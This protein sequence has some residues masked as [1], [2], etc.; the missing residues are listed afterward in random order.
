MI[1]A[2]LLVAIIFG[3]LYLFPVG[4]FFSQEATDEEEVEEGITIEGVVDD[5]KGR[6]SEVDVQQMIG[7]V[8]E[9]FDHIAVTLS[10]ISQGDRE[11]S[12]V[13]NPSQLEGYQPESQVDTEDFTPQEFEKEVHA[14]VNEE[15]EKEGLEPVEF[16]EEA[17]VVA[18]EKSRDMAVNNYFD[19][20]SPTYG[21]PFDMMD[22]FGLQYMAAGENIAMGQRS[23]EQVMDGWMNSD[24]H[25]A[26]ILSDSFTHLG[27]G[28]VQDGH[29]TYWTQMFIGK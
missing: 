14:L 10:Q 11:A 19:H 7:S 16:S 17:S 28:Y 20:Q 4:E 5:F 6:M 29:Q 15:R 18:R 27:V 23:P 22:E 3:A 26:N 12:P 13:F 8:V 21:S 9:T 1:R 24:G 2:I 25:R